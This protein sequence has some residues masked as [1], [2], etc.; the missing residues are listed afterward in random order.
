[1]QRGLQMEEEARQEFERITG[2]IVF[3]SVLF[4]QEHDWMMASLDGIDIEH[5][6]I[7]EIKCPGPHDHSVAINGM[8]PDKYYPQ[9]QHQMAVAGVN[10]AFYFSYDGCTSN[11]LEIKRNEVYQEELISKEKAFFR[12]MTTLE[13]PELTE[14]DYTLRDDDIWKQTA[15]NWIDVHRQLRDLQRQEESLRESLIC[16]C[17]KSNSM[18][19]GIKMSRVVRKG[20]IDYTAIP[21]LQDVDLERYRKRAIEMWRIS[22]H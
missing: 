14:K 12:C 8:I 19:N 17:G 6:H 9:L 7:V 2:I 21:E 20:N 5:K 16:M 15:K 18:G 10:S 3:P 4:H 22:P 1:M 13:T 11:V